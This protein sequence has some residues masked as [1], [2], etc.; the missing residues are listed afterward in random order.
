MKRSLFFRIFTGYSLIALA[1][2][3]VTIYLSA[4]IIRKNYISTLE[5]ELIITAATL[6]NDFARPMDATAK[7][8][9]VEL[10]LRITVIDATG[11]V[12]AESE[13]YPN[14]MDNHKER[15]EIKAALSGVNSASVRYSRTVEKEMIYAAVPVFDN[16]GAVTGCIRVSQPLKQIS[17]ILNDMM[18]D[19]L[20]IAA[21]VFLIA[22]AISFIAARRM[23]TPIAE[24]KKAADEISHGRLGAKAR[25]YGNDEISELAAAFNVM[26]QQI[27]TLVTQTIRQKEEMTSLISSVKEAIAL[28]DREGIITV[29][30][31]SFLK[32]AGADAAGRRYWEC[33]I[34]NDFNACVERAKKDK[35]SVTAQ[36]DVKGR[37]YLCS[38]T[39][40][41]KSS[42]AAVVL[43]DISELKEFEQIKK[44]FVA[45]VSHELRTPL[46]AIKGFAETMAP[47]MKGDNKKYLDIIKR[48]T[49]RLINIVQDLLVISRHESGAEVLPGEKADLKQVIGNVAAIF[50]QKAGEKGLA[51]VVAAPGEVAVKGD[52]FKL[53]QALI[54][55][56]D[57]AIKYTEKG[58]VTIALT[59]KENRAVITVQDT[60]SGIPAE[61]LSRVFER[62]YVVDKSRSRKLGGTGLGLA[63][64]KR[65][66]EL[67]SGTIRVESEEGRGTVFTIELPL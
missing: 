20:V 21:I 48:H 45:N 1:V 65:I 34:S 44:D 33:M 49:E 39:S 67:H 7:K 31:P 43:S 55:L 35:T 2:L 57:N 23:T 41:E 6:K 28:I 18:Q 51:L 37:T 3:A 60:G 36:I 42:E 52:A 16:G 53:E 64:V 24:L 9:G 27:K 62:F 61:H 22:L 40:I 5:K 32:V 19:V 50:E 14:T 47:D 8:L 59:K 38:V 56:V 11:K 25:V 46:T 66:V 29:C 13:A 54:N 12:L 30:N 26:S 58:S 10:G 17:D 15:P 63:I 4:G